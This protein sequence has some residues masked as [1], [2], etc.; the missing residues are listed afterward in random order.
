MN[1]QLDLTFPRVRNTDPA[2]SFQAADRASEFAHAH[3]GKILSALVDGP[4][5][6]YAIGARAG[7]SHVAVARRMPELE[8]FGKV[9]PTG[10]TGASP[11]G[12]QCR[13]WER[14]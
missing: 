5:T 7:L 10:R 11:S 6:I 4:G 14:T 1:K 2:T 12:R 3:H 9:R 8:Q 13:I